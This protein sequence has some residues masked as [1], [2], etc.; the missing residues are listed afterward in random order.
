MFWK[1]LLTF[2]IAIYLMSPSNAWPKTVKTLT[3]VAKVVDGDTLNINVQSIR[4][5][6]IDRPETQQVCENNHKIKSCS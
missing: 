1:I 4:T 6:S 5:C 2:S 3:S